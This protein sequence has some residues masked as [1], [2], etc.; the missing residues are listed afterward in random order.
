M[1]E[2]DGLRT[3]LLKARQAGVKDSSRRK[4][5]LPRSWGDSPKH[6]ITKPSKVGF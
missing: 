3:L 4:T 6:C 5:R 1:P 2:T